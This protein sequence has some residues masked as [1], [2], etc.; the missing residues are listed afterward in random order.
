[1][2]QLPLAPFFLALT[3]ILYSGAASRISA[4]EPPPP[5]K[6]ETTAERNAR[7]RAQSQPAQMEYSQ[8]PNV[9]GLS[10]E[11]RV[12]RRERQRIF[13]K[14]CRAS[15]GPRSPERDLRVLYLAF[16]EG[17]SSREISRRM[18]RG[19]TPSCVDSLVHRVRKRLARGG[20]SIPH[21]RRR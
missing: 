14:R 16:L 7:F 5:P 18:G 4:Q 6:Q 9:P 13:L 8:N 21:R 3:A 12:L 15:L 17:L 19:T 11:E 20:L 2:R 10:P 1:M